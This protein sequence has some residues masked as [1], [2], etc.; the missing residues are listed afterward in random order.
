MHTD[1]KGGVGLDCSIVPVAGKPGTVLISTHDFFY[2]LVEDP[3]LQGRIACCNVLSDL[4]SMGVQH[5]TTMLMTLGAS[6]D[7]TD[8][9][10]HIVTKQMIRGFSDL[11]KEAGTAVTGGQTVLN[12]WPIIGGVAMAVCNEADFVRPEHAVPGDVLVLTKPLGTQVAVNAHQWMHQTMRWLAFKAT[13][14]V[15]EDE[16]MRAYRSACESMGRLNRNGAALMHKYGAHCG[17]DVTGFG[18][19]GH[20]A[21]LA[22]SQRRK[23]LVFRLHTLPFLRGM[24]AVDANGSFKLAAGFSAGVNRYFTACLEE[25]HSSSRLQRPAVACWWHCRRWRSRRSS[26]KS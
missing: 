26:W 21:N 25:S 11:A 14:S 20:A 23:D 6:R 5:C 1:D 12:P 18:I 24:L 2:P 9:H 7:M 16:V 22:H 4:Y 13:S 19:L 15:S 10:R 17:T 3:Y 8:A